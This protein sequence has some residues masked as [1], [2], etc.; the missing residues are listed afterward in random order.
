MA[1]VDEILDAINGPLEPADVWAFNPASMFSVAV[2]HD[3]DPWQADFL[4]ARYSRAIIN[5]SRRSGK[6][7]TTACKALHHAM[8]APRSAP[9][10]VL[11]F[12][13]AGRQSDELLH[14][15]HVM[16][17]RLGRP[18]GRSTDRISELDF[19]N[20]SRIIPLPENPDTVR[21]YTPTL[22][23]VDE[24]SR[25]PENLFRA[26]APFRALAKC[27]LILLSTPNGKQ[28]FFYR[29][30]FG[31][32]EWERVKVTADQ[33]PRIDPRIIEE[34]RLSF[35]DEYVRQEYFGSFETMSGLVYP[36]YEKYIVDNDVPIKVARAF[37]G[38]DFGFHN[39]A[40]FELG[41]L[42]TDD[43]LW[44]TDEVYGRRLT[45]D[46][47]A[48]RIKPLCEQNGV[49][50]IWCDPS[51]AASIEKFRRFGLRALSAQNSVQPGIRTV[52]ER[53]RTGRLK[54]MRR[55]TELI[56]ELGLYR[57]YGEAE[58]MPTD[59]PVKESDHAPDAIRYLCT[60]I[61]GHVPFSAPNLPKPADEPIYRQANIQPNRGGRQYQKGLWGRG[62]G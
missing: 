45:D 6:T 53:M 41:K 31:Q 57:Y 15:L 44:I 27:L 33:C 16:Y 17:E 18:V 58:R 29:E 8:F 30:W 42:D 1:T 9:A 50:A 14:E 21:I 28:G 32:G 23:L 10:T 19:A 60:G 36:D 25:V 37:A 12:A 51:A 34:D 52:T 20:G 35:G 40:A 2:G 38:A 5:A 48:V 3:P 54:I 59:N 7:A 39:P 43:V 11:I 4:N 55:C 22:V 46:D 24:A 62:I 26:I 13:P 49:E 61:G 47:L 56:R